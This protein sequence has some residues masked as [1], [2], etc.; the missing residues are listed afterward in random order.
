MKP[1]ITAP[2][3]EILSSVN[4]SD[5]DFDRYSGTS[6]ASPHVTGAVALLIQKN[7]TLTGNYYLVRSALFG[8]AQTTGLTGSGQ[9]CGQIDDNTF[10][11]HVFGYGRLD[12]V[13]ASSK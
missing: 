1:E 5:D 2:G 6:M 4:T 3:V 9:S 13:A 12:I 7:P 11:N 8:G 10:P